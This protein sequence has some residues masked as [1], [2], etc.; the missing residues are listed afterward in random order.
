MKVLLLSPHTDDIELGAGGSVARLLEENHEFFWAVFSICE[1]AVPEGMP[2]NTLKEEFLNVIRFLGIKNYKIFNFKNKFLF[3]HRQEILDELWKIKKKFKPDLVIGPS[4][5][6]LHQDHNTIAMETFRCFKKDCSILGY[7]VPYNNSKFN[8][9]F[10]Y[11]LERRHI[12]KKIKMLDFYKSQYILNRNYF[13][14][15]YIYGL[16]KVRG[17][18]CNSKYAEVFEVIRWIE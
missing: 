1:D 17:V 11:R 14:R 12:E 13:S 6:D 2:K 3:K 5:D 16:A 10:F 8:F 9:D 15:E 7:E 4:L 18:Q